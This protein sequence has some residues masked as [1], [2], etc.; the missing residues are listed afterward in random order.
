MNKVIFTLAIMLLANNLW[1]IENKETKATK[2]IVESKP[3]KTIITLDNYLGIINQ[4]LPEFK[5]NKIKLEKSKNSVYRSKA[6]DDFR[7]NG[8]ATYSKTEQYSSG[9]DYTKGYVFSTGVEKVISQT[10]TRV[11]ASVDYT[12]MDTTLDPTAGGITT[13]A[14]QP[15]ASITVTQPLLY[16]FLGKVDRYA[17]TNAKANF[18]INKIRTDLQNKALT[19]YYKKLYVRWIQFESGLLILE[20]NIKTAKKL[21]NQVR[22]KVKRGLADNDEVQKAHSATLT[23]KI[24][25]DNYKKELDKLKNELS[26]FF[27]IKNSKPNFDKFSELYSTSLDL[28]FKDIDFGE[29]KNSELLKLTLKNLN[30]SLDVNENKQL[31]ELNLIGSV[32]QKSNEDSVGNSISNMKDTDYFVGFSMSYSLG[33]HENKGSLKDVR[34]SLKETKEDY[35][36]TKNSYNKDLSNLQ[37]SKQSYLNQ[38]KFRKQNL[39]SLKSQYRTEKTKYNQAR[40]NLSY[41]IQTENNIL[42]A[43]MSS[44]DLQSGLIMLMLDYNDLIK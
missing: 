5:Q 21:E 6:I 15:S 28:N 33:N 23:Y 24:T 37:T 29:T 25:Y 11:S 14:Y 19:T 7:F 20:K 17:K 34:L 13:N 22:R 41:L 35:I 31:P 27:D 30:Y 32:T 40:L 42:A 44:L 8:S 3:Q 18:E 12:Q 4:K 16:N 38:I 36:I 2:N 1:S 10:G 39:N 9:L 43:K 26:I